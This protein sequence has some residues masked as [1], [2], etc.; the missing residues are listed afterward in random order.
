MSR[1]R[2]DDARRLVSIVD[3]FASLRPV[4]LGD[5]V[6]DEFIHGDIARVSREA[7]VLVLDQRL[8]VIVPGAAGNSVANLRALG[9]APIPVGL[10]GRDEAGQR[11]LELFGDIGV[12]RAGITVASGYATPCKSRVLAG[13]VHTRRQQ[14]VRL[15]RGAPRGELSRELRSRIRRSL[16]RALRSG[17]GLLVADY[18]YGAASPDAGL[19]RRIAALRRRGLA[20]TV[21]SR[22]RVARFTGVTACSPNQEELEQALGVTGLEPEALAGGARELLRRTANRLVLVTRGASGMTLVEARRP[23]RHIPAYGSGEIA[24]VT[25]AGDTVIAVFTLALM[26]G[27]GPH[28]AARLSNYAAGIVVTKAGTATLAPDE[29]V[30]AVRGD[31]E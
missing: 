10:V 9:A 2:G 7:P 6:V 18:G 4:V 25:G 21:D 26:A 31:L 15:D 29:L 23:A 16:D 22:S 3:R 8:S 28:D 27:A 5:L 24:D 30:R 20:V 19:L 11:L 1:H 17:G 12:R 13:G 14:I